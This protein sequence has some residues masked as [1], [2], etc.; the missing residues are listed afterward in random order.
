MPLSMTNRPTLMAF[1]VLR[2]TRG[3]IVRLTFSR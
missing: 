2:S 3:L 1:T